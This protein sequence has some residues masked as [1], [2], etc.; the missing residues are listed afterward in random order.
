MRKQYFK[1]DPYYERELDTS[2]SEPE[3][4]DDYADPEPKLLEDLLKYFDNEILLI[5]KG[6]SKFTKVAIQLGSCAPALNNLDRFK[7]HKNPFDL[8]SFLKL[9]MQDFNHRIAQ[10]FHKEAIKYYPSAKEWDL[11]RP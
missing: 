8:H 4:R 6:Q 11:G 10:E 3:E 9:C 2:P 7:A 1:E 5:E